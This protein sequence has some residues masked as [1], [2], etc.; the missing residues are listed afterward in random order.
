MTKYE[1]L[2]DCTYLFIY[3]YMFFFIVLCLEDQG[4]P[5]RLL[6]DKLKEYSCFFS[7][8]VLSGKGRADRY[9]PIGH[10]T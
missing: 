10:L 1:G 4:K 8:S 2:A 6:N 7:E 3:I 9:R 5:W